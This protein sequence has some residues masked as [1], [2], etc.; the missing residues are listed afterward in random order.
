MP[1]T[2]RTESLES[3]S[4]SSDESKSKQATVAKGRR[5]RRPHATAVHVTFRHLEPSTAIQDYVE[6]KLGNINKFLKKD[7]VAHVVL[8]VDKYRHCGE[9]TVKAGSLNLKAAYQ[10]GRDLYAVIDGLADKVKRQITEHLNKIKQARTRAVPASTTIVSA[11]LAVP[12]AK[13]GR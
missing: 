8:S 10:E 6:R 9:A 12:E 2:Q 3:H 5:K 7:A 4:T 11:E 13:G 1:R